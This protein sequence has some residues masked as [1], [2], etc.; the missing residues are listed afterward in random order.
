VENGNPKAFDIIRLITDS[1]HHFNDLCFKI[2]T[3]ASTWL[4]ATFAG[5]GFVLTGQGDFVFAKT[6]VVILICWAGAVGV[7]VLWILDLQVY[8]KLLNTWFDARKEIEEESL[9]LPNMWERMRATQP[10]GRAANLIRFYYIATCSAPLLFALA[11]AIEKI[12][13][14][15]GASV[16]LAVAT[17]L[18]LLASILAIMYLSPA[19]EVKHE[20]GAKI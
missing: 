10:G 6:T 3:L 1:E 8:Q 14:G 11:I 7:F 13:R 17:A 12:N 5:V 16:I 9:Y 20:T 4:L 2:R 15:E 19:D 18:M